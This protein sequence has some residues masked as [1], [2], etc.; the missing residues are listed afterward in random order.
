MQGV[1]AGRA[2]DLRY[3][4]GVGRTRAQ[5]ANLDMIFME[6]STVPVKTSDALERVLTANKGPHTWIMSNPEFWRKGQP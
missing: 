5:Y 1:G 3:T 2:A 4:E 6:K